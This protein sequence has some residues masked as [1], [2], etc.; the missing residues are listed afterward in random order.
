MEH[1]IEAYLEEAMQAIRKRANEC[2]R[3]GQPLLP[4]EL[5]KTGSKAIDD[6]YTKETVKR[7]R[8]F[9]S[10]LT[11]EQKEELASLHACLKDTLEDF[12]S[13]TILA[14]SKRMS[15]LEI[16]KAFAVATVENAMESAGL[17]YCIE[18]TGNG[19]RLHV[20]LIKNKMVTLYMSYRD[21]ASQVEKVSEFV[22]SLNSMYTIYGTNSRVTKSS[23]SV[24]WKSVT[25]M[26]NME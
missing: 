16:K 22:D 8:I 4:F 1:S 6:M 17:T 24:Q 2:G 7:I 14:V 19:V 18:C 9:S 13:K 11:S 10:S 5:L 15:L 21:V 3:M 25:A 20:K 23:S 12:I 26:E